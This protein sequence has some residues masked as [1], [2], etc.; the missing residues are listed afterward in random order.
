MCV[1]DLEVWLRSVNRSVHSESFW[2][3]LLEISEG[4]SALDHIRPISNEFGIRGRMPRYRFGRYGP[5]SND[6]LL[7]IDSPSDFTRRAPIKAQNM[8]R[9]SG[10]MA[11]YSL[12]A[13][14]EFFE[15]GITRA[16]KQ[17]AASSSTRFC[18]SSYGLHRIEV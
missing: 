8:S 13:S 1:G 4:L 5:H 15:L 9:M 10:N 3:V 16:S 17:Q 12:T 18:M 14:V 11:R 6:A 7:E 2:C